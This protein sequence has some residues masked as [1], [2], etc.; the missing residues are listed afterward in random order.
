MYTRSIHSR[1][2]KTNSHRISR[3]DEGVGYRNNETAATA[4]CVYYYVVF[5]SSL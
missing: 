3:G 2:I 5:F 1:P 4:S